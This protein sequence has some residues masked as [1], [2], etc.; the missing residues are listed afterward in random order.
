MCVCLCVC[1][2]V[3]VCVCVCLCVCVCVCVC[4]VV[5][6]VVVV[7]VVSVVVTVFVFVLFVRLL[8]WWGIPANFFVSLC[9]DTETESQLIETG[10]QKT[11]NAEHATKCS[12]CVHS[13]T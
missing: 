2:Y 13:T 9:F 12:S 8:F 3:F 6:F 4:V 10:F 7:V 5:V 1:V 11:E